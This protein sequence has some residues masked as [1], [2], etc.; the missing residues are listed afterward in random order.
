MFALW[1][2]VFVGLCVKE[3]RCEM[4]NRSPAGIGSG[5]DGERR[6]GGSGLAAEPYSCGQMEERYG[7]ES[8]VSQ[9]KSKSSI[10]VYLRQKYVYFC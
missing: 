9:C 3:R 7:G 8:I 1:S 2:H 4:C 6:R 10:S 5:V